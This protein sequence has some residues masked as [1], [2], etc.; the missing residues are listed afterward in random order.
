MTN[1]N[2][3][4]TAAPDDATIAQ[5][6]RQF[7]TPTYAYDVRRMRRHV[8]KL[9][10]HLPE[11]VGI[12]YSLKVNAS[13]GVCDVFA[14]CGIGADVASTGELATAVAAGFAPDRVFVAGPFKSA[15]TI[16]QLRDLPGATV[17]VDSPSELQTLADQSL[18]N[19]LVLRLR[20][21]FGSAAVVT[22]GSDSD[23]K[24]VV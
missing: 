6:V 22:A 17:S 21:D 9:R 7:G 16:A 11:S 13:L 5:I 8:R 1:H 15:E 24:S 2:L 19:R 10:E 14:D 23:R 18:G 3:D 12:L 4:H 20:P